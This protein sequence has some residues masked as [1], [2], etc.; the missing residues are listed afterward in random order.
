MACNNFKCNHLMPLHF[1]GLKHVIILWRKR[2]CYSSLSSSRK[3]LPVYCCRTANISVVEGA[4][5]QLCISSASIA[6]SGWRLGLKNFSVLAKLQCTC[7]TQWTQFTHT[8]R[9]GIRISTLSPSSSSLSENLYFPQS[10]IE[11][12]CVT[13][14]VSWVCFICQLSPYLHESVEYLTS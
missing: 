4:P 7:S 13:S 1:K 10:Q 5:C 3:M 12:R 6:F 11:S 2:T 8:F 14:L 9:C